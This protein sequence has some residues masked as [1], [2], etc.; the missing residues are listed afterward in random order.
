MAAI[1]FTYLVDICVTPVTHL[2]LKISKLPEQLFDL[3]ESLPS[4]EA[5]GGPTARAPQGGLDGA[6]RPLMWP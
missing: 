1:E 5:N 6:N 3:A 4:M 2:P